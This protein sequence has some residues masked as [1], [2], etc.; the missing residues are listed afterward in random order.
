MAANSEL[1]T[2]NLSTGALTLVGAIGAGTSQ[3]LGLTAAL[4]TI[5]VAGSGADDTLVV[6]ATGPSSGSYS[7]NGGPAVPFANIASFSFLGGLGNDILTI[8]NPAGGLF[9]PTRGIDYQGGGQP[10][11]ALNLFGGGSLAYDQAYFVGTTTP[12]IGAGAGNNGDGLLRFTGPTPVDIRFTGLAPIVDTVVVA[13]FIVHSTDG[14]NVISVTDGS[15]APRLKVTVDAFE[16][17][18]FTNKTIVTVNA[19]DSVLGGDAADTITLNHSNVPAA[20]TSLN[21]FAGDGDD[22]V[23]ASS[24][25]AAFST[26]IITGAGNDSIAFGNGVSLNGGT[27]DGGADIDTI[28]Y[29]AYTT[30]VQVNLGLQNNLTSSLD[31]GQENPAAT[32]AAN[33]TATV[34]YNAITRQATVSMS[35]NNLF[36]PI[37]DSHIHLGPIGA[38]GP[39]IVPIGAGV[40]VPTGTPGQFTANFVSNIPA[41]NEA[42]FL[43]GL[44]YF[45]IHTNPGFPGGEIRG[46]IQAAT[47]VSIGTGTATGT[48]SISNIENATGGSGNDSLVGNSA[49]NILNGMA[50]NDVLVGGPGA[51]SFLG[52]ANNDTMTWNPGDGSDVMDGQADIDTVQL[53]GGNASE[54]FAITPNGT[55]VSFARTSPGPFNLDVGTTEVLRLNA[56]GGDDTVS[57]G[58][59]TGVADVTTVSLFGQ[60]G[61]DAFN[62]SA[63]PGTGLLPM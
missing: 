48:A 51:D 45:N 18:E 46:Q 7:L 28:D 14:S 26:N 42:A 31:G 36:N 24:T 60:D 52:G 5:A 53:N 40:F 2:A 54:N 32:T 1:Y 56:N 16:S 19:D 49:A 30:A 41:T 17:V 11:D 29:S 6:N 61:N 44:T 57:L 25:G 33:G 47:N 59:L 62:V 22:I 10:G 38:N 4:N 35:V 58:D 3:F 27:V 12:P 9:A 8:N 63:F 13:N 50:G 55:R 15:V 21:I 34:S 37:S 43:G 23:T 20:L 39:V